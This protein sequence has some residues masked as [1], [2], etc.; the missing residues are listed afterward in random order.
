MTHITLK[1]FRK[2]HELFSVFF[3]L[4]A[5]LITLPDCKKNNDKSVTE[6]LMNKW[7]LVQIVDTFYSTAAPQIT[8]YTGKTT[9]YMDFRTDGNLYSYI[10]NVYDTAGYTYSEIKLNL[11]VKSHHY[12]I[13]TLTDQ[14]M[15]LYDPRYTTAMPGYTASKVTLK[16]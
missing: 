7:T 10:N 5:A 16:R 3:L 14:S 12:T 9:D 1:P 8:P 2:N 11:D 4:G 13:L 15:V 6:R